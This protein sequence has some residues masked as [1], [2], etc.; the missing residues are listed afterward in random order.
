MTIFRKTLISLIGM[1]I[2]LTIVGGSLA[3]AATSKCGDR[4]KLIEVLKSRYKEVPVALGLSEKST[5]AFEI[6]AS[7]KGTWTVMMTMS[8][9]KTCVM[10]AGHSWQNLPKQLAGPIT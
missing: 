4:T 6:F 10:A 1:A 2:V 9:G 8:N 7:D 3:R 5:E